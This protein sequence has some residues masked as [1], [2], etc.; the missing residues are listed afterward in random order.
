MSY[1]GWVGVCVCQSFWSGRMINERERGG[2]KQ[3]ERDKVRYSKRVKL[4]EREGG[5]LIES[6]IG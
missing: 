2:K 4:N 3:E 6:G 5:Q 1:I